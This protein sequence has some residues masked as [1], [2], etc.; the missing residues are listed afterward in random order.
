MLSQLAGR[1]QKMNDNAISPVPWSLLAA[2][3]FPLVERF[4]H[5]PKKKLQNSARWV[6]RYR[7]GVL[8]NLSLGTT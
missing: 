1:A 8:E 2:V 6:K 5:F 3:F 4:W 7:S